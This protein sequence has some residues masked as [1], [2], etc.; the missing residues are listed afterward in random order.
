MEA[1]IDYLETTIDPKTG[2]SS[3]GQLGDWLGPQNNAL[4]TAF[5]VT[6][7]H[8]YDLGIMAKVADLL[9]KPPMRRSTAACTRSGRPS[10]TRH[11]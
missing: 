6:A 4:G 3:D 7:Y 5:L 11:S 2:L 1:Y 10:S 9:G 8:A